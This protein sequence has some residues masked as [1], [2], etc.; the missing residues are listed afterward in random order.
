MEQNV[1]TFSGSNEKLFSRNTIENFSLKTTVIV[2]ETHNAILIKD[3]Q[4]LQTLASGKYLIS[5]F[6]DLKTEG[7]SALEVLFM[8]KTA[9]L[10]LLWGTSSKF[11]MYDS[12][13]Q[14]NYRTGMSGDFEV[15]IGDPR[16]CYLYLVGVSNDLT[17]DALQERLMSN[18]VSV[19]ETV[20]VDYVE[21]N[22]VLYNQIAQYKKE[23]SAKVLNGLSQKLMNEYGIAVFSFNI[24][25]IIIENDDYTKLDRAYKQIKNPDKFTCK[26]CGAVLNEND[27]FCSKC[28]KRVEVAKKCPKCFAEN[29]DDS[30]FCSEC[31]NI[32]SE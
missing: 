25:N 29:S 9:K 22:K 20:V 28:G 23:I 14:E 30:K 5:K 8:S 13:L 11:L 6:V 26:G 2:P 4:M 18:V 10:K 1:I 7:D 12:Q 16:K 31:G 27:K 17:A 3:G 32:M 24:A 21:A 19:L 15:Q